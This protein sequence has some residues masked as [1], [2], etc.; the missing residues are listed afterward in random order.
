MNPPL[1]LTTD[2]RDSPSARSEALQ[3]LVMM[4]IGVVLGLIAVLIVRY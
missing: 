3:M 1:P 4:A 2:A